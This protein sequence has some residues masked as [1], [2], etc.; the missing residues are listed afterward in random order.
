MIGWRPTAG[1][2]GSIFSSARA[3]GFLFFLF[4]PTP[5]GQHG[6]QQTAWHPPGSV[7]STCTSI[8]Y[9]LGW[10]CCWFCIGRWLCRPR[11]I[12]AV[13]ERASKPGAMASLSRMLLAAAARQP[14][15]RPSSDTA[16]VCKVPAA[17]MSGQSNKSILFAINVTGH[18]N[19]QEQQ[20]Q[21]RRQSYS[22]L[23]G[24]PYRQ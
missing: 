2:L 16:A 6:A 22:R 12:D 17:L 9:A 4:L 19:R 20:Q 15:S 24:I 21:S 23:D 8:L 7:A 1:P 14:G 10:A 13:D 18:R 5:T 3:L 11:S